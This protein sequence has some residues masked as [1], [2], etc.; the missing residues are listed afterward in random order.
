MKKRERNFLGYKTGQKGDC[1]LDQRNWKAKGISTFEYI[2]DLVWH[3]MATADTVFR[4][5]VPIEKHVG[6]G[7][8]RLN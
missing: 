4:K 6:I 1:K 8:W 7:L 3:N 2:I 5:E